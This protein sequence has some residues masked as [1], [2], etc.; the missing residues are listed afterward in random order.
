MCRKSMIRKEGKS[1]SENPQS[2]LGRAAAKIDEVG[3]SD[4]GVTTGSK[5][6]INRSVGRQI[7]ISQ[8]AK[9]DCLAQD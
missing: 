4:C 5:H 8:I 7:T 2:T 1:K 9:H 6:E 3:P